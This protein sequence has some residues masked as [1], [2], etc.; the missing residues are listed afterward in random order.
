MRTIAFDLGQVLFDFDYNLALNKLKDKLKV[1]P[2]EVIYALYEKD[3][4]LD[5]EKGLDKPYD[6]YLRFKEN[7]LKEISYDEFVDAWCDIFIP[8]KEV[9]EVA[10][11]VSLIY[12]TYLISNIN[13]LHFDFLYKRYKEV[14]DIFDKLILSYEVKSIKP[15]LEI[16][17]LLTE[18][19]NIDFKDI[20][21]ID[22]REDLIRE[23]VLFGLDC[24]K[25]DGLD[26]LMVE[27]KKRNVIFPNLTDSGVLYNF[28]KIINSYK[29][30]LFVG[31]GNILRCDDGVGARVIEAVK[32]KVFFDTLIVNE[33]FEN[34][35]GRISKIDYDLIVFLDAGEFKEDNYFKLL[36][37]ESLRSVSLY[38]THDCSLDLNIKYLKNFKNFDIVILVIKGVNFDLC[39]NLSIETKNAK[40]ILENF[41]LKNFSL[42]K[43]INEKV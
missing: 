7:F 27:L 6:F 15:E 8:K 5:F 33:C 30:V 12:P 41:L 2:Q 36:N 16:Y 38:S 34:Y 19:E 26:N 31:I 39:D 13:K 29:K 37:K 3:F 40:F 22:D 42:P 17:K 28:K 10:K 18:P 4:A 35:I 43:A 21:Y 1:T 24:I 11:R 23:A 9:I 20:I 32:D 25:F 14:F